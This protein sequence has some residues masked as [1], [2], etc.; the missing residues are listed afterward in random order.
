MPVALANFGLYPG[1]VALLLLLAANVHISVVMWRVR[2]FCPTCIGTTTYTGFVRGAFAKAPAWQRRVMIWITGFCQKSFIVGMMVLYLMSAGKGMGM[3]FYHYHVCLP[4]WM[5]YAA[6]LLLPFAATARHMSSWQSLVWLNVATLMGSVLIP[7]SFESP[8]WGTDEIFPVPES[9]V[10]MV[11]SLNAKVQISQ[12]PTLPETNSSP[13]EMPM[14]SGKYH[15]KWWIFQPAMLVY[16]SVS[17]FTFWNDF[18]N[19]CC[20][21][22]SLRWRSR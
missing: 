20:S 15:Q 16:R 14:F 22:S 21:R 3:L 5:I 17:T 13:M 2:M 9:E 19:L 4:Q 10:E 7:L 18:C 8:C 12:W 11:S 6:L 1:I